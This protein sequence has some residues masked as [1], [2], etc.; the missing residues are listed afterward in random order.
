MI[1]SE[2]KFFAFCRFKFVGKSHI[3]WGDSS[4]APWLPQW[5]SCKLGQFPRAPPPPGYAS[6]AHATEIIC[7]RAKRAAKTENGCINQFLNARINKFSLYIVFFSF[8]L[9]SF[10]LWGGGGGQKRVLPPTFWI[11]GG[12]AA[13]P[14]P[15][16]ATSGAYGP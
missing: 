12:A 4:R 6:G 1:A 13:A 14:P 7:S 10:F 11:G 8:P 2:P 16:P 9:F 3:S 15:L 5:G